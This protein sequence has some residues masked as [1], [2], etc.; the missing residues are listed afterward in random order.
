M[1]NWGRRHFTFHDLSEFSPFFFV[2][3]F[4]RANA[5]CLAAA[6]AAPPLFFM[7]C[8]TLF[9]L[10]SHYAT[11]PIN[12]ACAR[13]FLVLLLLFSPLST[14]EKCWWINESRA[15]TADRWEIARH[16][17]RLLLIRIVSL[18]YQRITWQW[19]MWTKTKGEKTW[20]EIAFC[21]HFHVS[22]VSI[23]R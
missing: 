1:R 8:Q 21:L 7:S 14:T 6:R 16:F 18:S 13:F 15:M 17:E 2:A 12:C 11:N 5:F 20:R 4:F 9:F 10:T 3:T 23:P 19:R 22:P